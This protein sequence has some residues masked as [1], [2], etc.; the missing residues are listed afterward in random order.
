MLILIA[1]SK[2][3]LVDQHP[4]SAEYLGAHMPE[5][6]DAAADIVRRLAEL[7]QPDL[8]ADTGFSATLAARVRR[9]LYEFPNK[10]LGLNAIEA[11]TGVVFKA[12]DY[13]TLSAEARAM[14]QKEVRIIS[15]LYGLLR[16]DDVIKPYRLDF[17]T[18]AAPNGGALNAF[19]R[20]DV[21]IDLVKTITAAGH[22]DVLNLL[23]ADAAKCVNWKV[24]RKFCKVWKADFVEI[25]D[26]DTFK[27]PNATKLKT[28]RGKLLRQ[29]LT[30]GIATAAALQTVHSDDYFCLGT[31]EYPDHLRFIT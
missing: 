8:I 11:Y 20:K 1:E 22:T 24:V 25:G 13:A 31:P 15:S 4:V 21:T 14:C 12:L 23:P 3:M 26:G 6:E 9:M 27:T 10:A 18:K 17:T 16:P 2:T 19:L 30:D 7:S 29:I 28:M 5:G